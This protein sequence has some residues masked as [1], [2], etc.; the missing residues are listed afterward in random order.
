V[1]RFV[2]FAAVGMIVAGVVC[3][4]TALFVVGLVL[5]GISTVLYA[6]TLV[7][8]VKTVNKTMR[9]VKQVEVRQPWR[10]EHRWRGIR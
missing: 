4:I 10:D 1:T 3:G 8:A 6:A 9:H 7:V 2:P 5:L